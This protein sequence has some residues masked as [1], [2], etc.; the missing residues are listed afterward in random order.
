[1]EKLN[2][3]DETGS[4]VGQEY[5]DVIHQ[6][7]LL[8]AEVHVW[9]TT[10]EDEIIFQQRAKDKDTYPDLLDATAGGH[11]D[12]GETYEI[13]AMKELVEETGIIATSDELLYLNTQ[14]TK[15]YDHVTGLINHARR[16]I[17]LLTNK[18]PVNE[19][20]IEE[21]AGAGFVSYPIDQMFTLSPDEQYKF[22]P[23]IVDESGLELFAKLKERI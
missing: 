7:G 12:L 16:N 9:C 19:L 5:R 8:H 2:V 18:V 1:M 3:L 13:A 20:Q 4:I 22:V 23:S 17:Y 14:I 11:V 10:P 21:G 15:Q 6:K